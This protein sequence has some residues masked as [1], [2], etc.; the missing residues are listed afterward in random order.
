M[1]IIIFYSTLWLPRADFIVLNFSMSNTLGRLVTIFK[2][3]NEMGV[4]SW[5]TFVQ[6]NS[7]PYIHKKF[8]LLRHWAWRLVFFYHL[9]TTTPS[10]AAPVATVYVWPDNSWHKDNT[11]WLGSKSWTGDHL[12]LE[13]EH[14]NHKTTSA[15]G[16]TVINLI[17]TRV[18]MARL[19]K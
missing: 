10:P 11:P 14:R 12:L 17:I 15:G 18:I 8:A 1:G 4:L 2:K 16:V 5:L 13:G 3:F 9:P 19:G 7:I 6:T